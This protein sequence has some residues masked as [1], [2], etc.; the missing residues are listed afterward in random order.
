MIQNKIL[1]YILKSIF[2][3]IGSLFIE[4]ALSLSRTIAQGCCFKRIRRSGR[5]LDDF[6]LERERVFV[7]RNFEGHLGIAVLVRVR[8]K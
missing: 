3:L 8:H 6:P 7:F 2:I 5:R 4:K 1:I